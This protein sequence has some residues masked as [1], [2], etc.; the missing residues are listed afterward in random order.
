M[1]CLAGAKEAKQR[2]QSPSALRRHLS[3]QPPPLLSVVQPASEHPARPPSLS[4]S[5]IVAA[6]FRS[7]PYRCRRR[8]LTTPPSSRSRAT[9]SL[10]PEHR[11]YIH[12][13][14]NPAPLP[15]YSG[16]LTRCLR[17][18]PASLPGILKSLVPSTSRHLL[19]I[20]ALVYSCEHGWR[21]LLRPHSI[22][23]HHNRPTNLPM[24]ALH[25]HSHGRATRCAFLV[26][27]VLLTSPIAHRTYDAGSTST[28]T[29][30]AING[31]SRRL[32]KS[33]WLKQ[34]SPPNRRLQ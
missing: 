24:Q 7:R 1:R 4:S 9:L 22:H 2:K 31:G 14:Q 33:Y 15:E 23:S 27:T 11:V 26:S 3:Q 34:T 30:I 10:P 18:A 12:R 20:F 17:T 16:T 25:L 5:A 28:S 13:P 6:R 21:P 29:T 19:S 32:Q 8:L